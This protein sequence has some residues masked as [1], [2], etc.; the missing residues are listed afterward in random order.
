VQE[1]MMR[2]L[3]KDMGIKIAPPAWLIH[4]DADRFL[5]R[6][7]TLQRRSA[8]P[9]RFKFDDAIGK[10]EFLWSL[11]KIQETIDALVA[12]GSLVKFEGSTYQLANLEEYMPH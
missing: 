3:G 9:V 8:Q 12:T 7:Q 4:R 5:Q 2:Q 10:G 6:I 11:D 1:A